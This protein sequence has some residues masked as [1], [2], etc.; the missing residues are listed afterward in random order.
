M[1]YRELAGRF[2]PPAHG[3]ASF[4]F[5]FFKIICVYL[6]IFGCAWVFAARAFLS[7]QRAAA[8]SC[9][10]QASHGGGFSCCT[11]RALACGLQYLLHVGL[12]PSCL[13]SFLLILLFLLLLPRDE[14]LGESG[15]SMV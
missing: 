15:G 13:S 10:A 3:R 7:L 11:A 5:F 14:V 6:F 4:F 12:F 1:G 2:V 9:G 8:V